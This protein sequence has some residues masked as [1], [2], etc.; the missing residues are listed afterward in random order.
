[1]QSTRV[2]RDS[3]LSPR[4]AHHNSLRGRGLGTKRHGSQNAGNSRPSSGD[5]EV[6][7]ESI[8]ETPFEGKSALPTG[9]K[10]CERQ[11]APILR[12]FLAV[13]FHL[14]MERVS[15]E[16]FAFGGAGRHI[17]RRSMKATGHGGEQ[18]R[19]DTWAV[20]D[21]RQ[22]RCRRRP[23]RR[24]MHLSKSHTSAQRAHQLLLFEMRRRQRW[25][26]P[27]RWSR[28]HPRQSDRAHRT[29]AYPW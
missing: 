7:Y 12:E 2:R 14:K 5:L 4:R 15:A 20:M 22:C 10:R 19:P 3:V 24:M 1:V 27:G 17:C 29:S 25:C 23:S 16:R 6:E 18:L 13:R 28:I 8:D 11:N 9:S 21:T 26:R